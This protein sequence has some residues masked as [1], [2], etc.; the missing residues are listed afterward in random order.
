MKRIEVGELAAYILRRVKDER[1][2]DFLR[3]KEVIESVRYGG[4]KVTLEC[5]GI[6]KLSFKYPELREPRLIHLNG[7]L[8]DHKKWDITEE[9]IAVFENIPDSIIAHQSAK[10]KEDVLLVK[11]VVVLPF[12]H[13]REIRMIINNDNSVSYYLEKEWPREIWTHFLS[14]LNIASNAD[15]NKGFLDCLIEDNA[16]EDS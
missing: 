6:G 2:S 14:K 7:S 5:E 15:S 13:D 11:N 8:Y 9:Y 4:V 10:I 12:Y 1:P 16:K 3:L